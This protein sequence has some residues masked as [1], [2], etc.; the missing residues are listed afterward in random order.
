MKMLYVGPLNEWGTCYSRFVALRSLIDDIEVLDTNKYL[1]KGNRVVNICENILA[2][3]PSYHRCNSALWEKIADLNPQCLWVDKGYWISPHILK[4]CKRKK[5]YIVEH[6]T[7]DLFTKHFFSNHRRLRS[8]LRYVDRFCSTNIFN[9]NE[10]NNLYP[11]T[12]AFFTHHAFDERWFDCVRATTR[13]HKVV[14]AGHWEPA[15]DLLMGK[16]A[17]AKIQFEVYGWGWH[18]TRHKR[19]LGNAIFPG[20]LIGK[21]Y[22][23]KLA[24]SQI[25]LGLLSKWNRNLSTPRIY[26]IPAA[27]A[28]LLAERT[29]ETVDIFIDQKEA[30][31]F[32]SS[33][34]LIT[35]LK[36]LLAAP[37]LVEEIAIAGHKRCWESKYTWT[38]RLSPIVADIKLLA[39]EGSGE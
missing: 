18:R 32:S 19:L 8:G 22:V 31:F 15:S 33:D 36:K 39:E 11:E 25:A 16:L 38:D 37:A 5:I 6:V 14:F 10:V 9:I 21:D 23:D 28:L 4:E 30:V 26:E 29:L 35:H 27:G 3:G 13:P 7:D 17:N 24:H 20:Y 2:F 12:K 34:E 1:G